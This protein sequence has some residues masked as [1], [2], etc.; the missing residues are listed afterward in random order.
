MKEQE[1][2]RKMRKALEEMW[3]LGVTAEQ[4]FDFPVVVMLTFV[5]L[6]DW[7]ILDILVC[8]NRTSILSVLTTL[9]G[10]PEGESRK[11]TSRGS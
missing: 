11:A 9:T 7:F 4:V 5:I 2:A 10:V 1:K 3:R 6:D 8:L